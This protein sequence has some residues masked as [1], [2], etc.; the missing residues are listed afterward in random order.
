MRK[1][2]KKKTKN[3]IKIKVQIVKLKQQKYQEVNQSNQ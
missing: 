2:Q 3:L 1:N